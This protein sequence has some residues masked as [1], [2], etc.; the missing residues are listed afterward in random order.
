MRALKLLASIVLQPV[1]FGAMLF[2]PAQ[3]LD[4]P[5]A[6]VFLAVV[7]I[8]S[9]A[10]MLGVFRD[11]EELLN[12]RYKP[13]VQRGQPL[14]DKVILLAL[15]LAFIGQVVFIPLDV[16]HYR[17]L[18]NPGILVSSLGLAIFIGGWVVITLAFKA[19]AFAAPVVKH[20]VERHQRVVDNGV[21]RI[22]RHPM[23]SGAILIVVGQA[24]W[25]GS[26]AAALAAA[27]PIAV[28]ALRIAFEERFLRRELS[29]YEQYAE[30]TR[31]RMI[32]FVW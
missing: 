15:L 16:F 7:A 9:A 25:L 5:R 26:Y 31:Y 19:N 28:L 27:V 13:P 22:V 24:L 18:G 3:R 10:T 6:W 14:S 21:Y 8:A 1:L 32:P 20:Q 2:L 23:Y 11:N 30:R 29:G 17:L 12:E 4:W